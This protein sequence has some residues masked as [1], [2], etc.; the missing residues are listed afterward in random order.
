MGFPNTRLRRLRSSDTI[1]NMLA[2]PMP[3]PEKFVWPVFVVEGK[4]IK[5]AIDAMPGQFRYSIDT[6]IEAVGE[7]MTMGIKSI[8]VF[9][10]VDSKRKSESAE[11][12]WKQD[13]LVQQAVYQ[14]KKTYP[15]LLIFTDVCVCEYTSHGHCGILDNK[16][17][18]INDSSLEL[19]TKTAVSHAQAG[20]DGV[21]PSA[22]IDGQIQ[23]IRS[24]LDSANLENTILMSYSSKFASSMYGP[25]REAA[26]S[27][28]SCGDRKSYQADYRN[29]RDAIRESIEDES[30]G[31]D[32]LMVKPSLFY[33]D[34]IKQIK[35]ESMLPLAAYNVSGEYSMLIATADKGW[36][37]LKSMVRE[38]IFALSR[39]GSDI[40]ISYWANQYDKFLKD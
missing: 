15:D 26:D 38:S 35:Q 37:D 31:A 39:A 19:L 7:V 1:R 18:L 12:A 23:A 9:G 3:G 5:Q 14:I 11:Y 4:G 40:V 33:L 16:G 29:Q 34:I 28:P 22:M 25:F 8:M 27:A 17:Y 36:G 6:L 10:V 21:A 30:E 32:I 13:G 2:A 20:A 24:S